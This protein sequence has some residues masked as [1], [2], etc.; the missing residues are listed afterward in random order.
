MKIVSEFVKFNFSLFENL[1]IAKKLEKICHVSLTHT[2][3]G[4]SFFN[5]ASILLSNN[6]SSE[7]FPER[8]RRT[9]PKFGK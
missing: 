4:K 3:K 6:A 7:P 8:R 1:I 9:R 5:S 2:I